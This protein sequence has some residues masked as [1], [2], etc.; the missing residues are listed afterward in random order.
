MSV[1][2]HFKLYIDTC[3]QLVIA[4]GVIDACYMYMYMYEGAFCASIILPGLVY[5]IAW[6]AVQFGINCTSKV[7]NFTRRSRVTLLT[8]AA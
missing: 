4:P 5:V 8:Y 2:E 3:R 1:H 7:C 6:F